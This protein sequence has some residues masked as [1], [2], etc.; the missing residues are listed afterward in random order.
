[1]N[2][3]EIYTLKQRFIS[4]AYQVTKG[5]FLLKQRPYV[6]IFSVR[7]RDYLVPLT[8]GNSRDRDVFRLSTQKIVFSKAFP[9]VN[10]RIIE[11]KFISSILDVGTENE[12][13]ANYDKIVRQFENYLRCYYPSKYSFDHQLLIE[14]QLSNKY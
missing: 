9:L 6:L 8:H 3:I 14:L 4:D 11:A 2:K 7:G 13:Q 10:R 5:Q 12:L 1:M